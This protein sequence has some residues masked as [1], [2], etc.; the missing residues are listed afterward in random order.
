MEPRVA[1]VGAS[2]AGLYAAVQLGR[3][4]VP[5]TVYEASEREPLPRSLIVTSAYRDLLG[6]LGESAVVNEIHRFELYA[7]GLAAEVPLQRPD[8]IIER[9]RLLQALDEAAR[10]A[11]VEVRRGRRLRRVRFE[12]EGARLDFSNG[13]GSARADVVIGADGAR[14]RV[15]RSAGFRR[16]PVVPLLQAIVRLP[17][18]MRADS[19]RVWFV[20]DDTPYFYWL[21]PESAER[22]ALGIIGC[23]GAETRACLDAFARKHD[24]EVLGYQGARIPEY[25]G[26]RRNRRRVGR[27]GVYLVGDAAG[28][29]KVTTIGGIVNG[30]WGARGVAQ[31]VAGEC[32]AARR[33]LRA[34]R[35]ELNLHLWIR[36]ALHHF[37]E[38]DYRALILMLDG[39]VRRT[40]GRFHRDQTPA[41]MARLLARRPALLLL[42]IRGLLSGTVRATRRTAT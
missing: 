6:S 35:R 29:V 37:D 5:T 17:A 1:V 23:S 25:D 13:S 39:A 36:R 42:G 16:M 32:A 18:D 12:G 15:A 7:D 33:T 20:P 3:R 38:D 40:L 4:S 9:A 24:L 34:L 26:W 2:V 10:E 11:G 14:S 21:I 28:H 30:V 19:T 41:L 8:L 27:T 22:G 31:H